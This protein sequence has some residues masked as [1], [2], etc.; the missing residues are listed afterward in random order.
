[1]RVE[2]A[3]VQKHA[4]YQSF[5]NPRTSQHVARDDLMLPLDL[6]RIGAQAG[7][8]CDGLDRGGGLVSESLGNH[9]LDHPEVLVVDAKVVELADRIGEVFGHRAVSTRG[10][11][12]YVRD[13]GMG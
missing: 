2:Q 7:R 12:Q 5:V 4:L 13:L 3:L 1:V 8:L 11:G 9:F 6:A 10:L